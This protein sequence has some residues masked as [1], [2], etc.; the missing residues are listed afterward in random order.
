MSPFQYIVIIQVSLVSQKT[1]WCTPRWSTFQ[2]SIT[3]YGNKLHKRTSELSMWAQKN[4]W[5]TSLQ[6]HFHGKPLNIFTKDLVL[7]LLQKWMFLN[8]YLICLRCTWGNTI[9]GQFSQGEQPWMERY[10]CHWWQRGRDLTDLED[11]GMVPWGEYLSDA[12]DR[13]MVPRGSDLSDAEEHE[14]YDFSVASECCHQCQR[15]RLLIKVG[16]H[17]CQPLKKDP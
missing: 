2:S 1:W 7:F 14:W 5:Q 15:G 8:S 4:K 3:F 12:E 17:W 6:N 11:R 16:C 10:L 9:R 13:G